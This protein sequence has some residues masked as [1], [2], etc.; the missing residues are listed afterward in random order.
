[1][2]QKTLEQWIADGLLANW[3]RVF[4]S[5]NDRVYTRGSNVVFSA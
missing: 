2:N 5:H 1:M 3:R 4:T